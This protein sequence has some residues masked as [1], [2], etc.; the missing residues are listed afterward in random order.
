M[1]FQI[2]ILV[3]YGKI[4]YFSANELHQNSNVSSKE[5]YIQRILTVFN[6][7][8]FLCRS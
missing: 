4:L 3:N 8:S 1:G 6:R 5:E 7:L 2:F